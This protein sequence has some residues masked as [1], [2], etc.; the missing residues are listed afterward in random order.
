MIK[1]SQDP[2]YPL[3]HLFLAR[4]LAALALVGHNTAA[5]VYAKLRRYHPYSLYVRCAVSFA[6]MILYLTWSGLALE[7]F[8]LFEQQPWPG[9]TPLCFSTHRCRVG[10]TFRFW[11]RMN[12]FWVPQ[13][14]AWVLLNPF[15]LIDSV[16]HALDYVD[17]FII[18][19][20]KGVFTK[21]WSNLV[22]SNSATYP[23]WK[24]MGV[25]SWSITRAMVKT[26]GVMILVLL[27]SIFFP[28]DALLPIS[29]ILLGLVW[30][31][32]DVVTVKLSNQ[33]AVVDALETPVSQAPQNPE[34]DFGI[35]QIFPLLMGL[36][37]VM[38]FLDAC[39][40][41]IRRMASS[42]P[43]LMNFK[44]GH[45]NKKAKSSSLSSSALDSVSRIG[46]ELHISSSAQPL[47][48]TT[49][50]QRKALPEQIEPAHVH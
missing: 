2:A 43:S 8:R 10:G 4:S 35:G 28:T 23:M 39:S 47:T 15:K 16:E 24:F 36:Q 9:F 29:N 32:Y 42:G 37:L 40:G 18:S 48:S 45:L 38:A 34:Q 7:R 6:T 25:I 17:G 21:Y 44:L 12:M 50:I 22:P 27:S 14:F 33:H 11:I 26:F 31:I 30:P 46:P 1:L 49:V 20:I 19:L 3:Y 41:R 5:F 13:S